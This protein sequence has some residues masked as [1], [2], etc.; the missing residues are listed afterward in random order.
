[1]QWQ[2]RVDL[3]SDGDLRLD[4][5]MLEGTPVDLLVAAVATCFVKSC[6]LVQEARGDAKSAVHCD[7][8]GTKAEGPPNRIGHMRIAW[9]LPGLDAAQ[10]ERIAKDAKRICTVTNSLSCETEMVTL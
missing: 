7:V 9:S 10:A 8:T 6:H 5:P 2:A 1:M 3:S 4:S